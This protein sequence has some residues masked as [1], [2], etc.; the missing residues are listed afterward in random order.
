MTVNE[1]GKKLKSMYELPGANKVAMI[2]PQS[3]L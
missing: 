2:A 1:L 3:I